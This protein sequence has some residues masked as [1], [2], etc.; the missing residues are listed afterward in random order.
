MSPGI[1]LDGRD[2]PC[3]A[4]VRTWQDHGCRFVPSVHRRIRPRTQ[5]VDTIVWHWTG[6]EG[7]GEQV[8]Q[9][10][11]SRGL[12]VEFAIDRDGVIWQYC[13]P[14]E[15]DARDCGSWW[16]RFSV[17]VEIVCYG[18]R[19][20]Y[21]QRW[22]LLAAPKAARDR[23]L[24]ETRLR[25]RR[26]FVADF[27]PEQYLAASALAD[28]LRTVYPI[29]LDMPRDADG[30]VLDRPV[31]MDERMGWNG[32]ELGHLQITSGAKPDPGLPF[33]EHR[34]RALGLV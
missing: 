27:Y 5:V 30:R 2:V 8:Y 28:A 13:D 12:G 24:V 31:T 7:P 22:S 4:P 3:E 25:G 29:S 32:G 19:R 16:D 20:P 1:I 10:L 6:G 9:T 21:G 33:L 34:A 14:G 11:R 17:G 15:A 26:V 18:M 23:V